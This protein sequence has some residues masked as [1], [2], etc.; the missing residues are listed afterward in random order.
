MRTSKVDAPQGAKGGGIFGT[1]SDENTL[2]VYAYAYAATF[3]LRDLSPVFGDAEVEHDKDCLVARFSGVKTRMAVLFDFGSVVLIGLS[4]E[5][6]ER[7]ISAIGARIA[8]EPHP[9]LT[10]DFLVEVRPGAE[11][12]VQFD[13][14][15]LSEASVSALKVISLVL[16]QSAAMDY[17]DEDVQEIQQRT[18]VITR[19]LQAEGRVPGRLDKLVQFIGSCIETKNG[20]IAT[21]ALFD[22]PD[23]TWDNQQID[24]IYSGLRVELEIDDRFR[25][26]E[27]KLRMIQE[28]LVLLADLYH[29]RS[30]WRLELTVVLLIL[31]EILLNLWNLFRGG[32]HA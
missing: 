16:A 8:P 6:R 24:R 7:L 19:A 18:H 25:A 27:A 10:E 26:L 3:R 31:F 28:N 23:A 11:I 14:V 1:G 30:T 12:E 9:P 17:Y 4:R 13:R 2:H 22:K 5:E 29:S 15:I 20:M 21:L 32:T